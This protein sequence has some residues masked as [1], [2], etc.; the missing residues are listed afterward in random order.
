[1]DSLFTTRK[2][3]QKAWRVMSLTKRFN[4]SG[5][6]RQR[7]FFSRRWTRSHSTA[8]RKAP[9]AGSRDRDSSWQMDRSLCGLF[10]QLQGSSLKEHANNIPHPRHL[11]ENISAGQ[12]ALSLTSCI[13][14][15]HL[16]YTKIQVYL[17]HVIILNF[18]LNY[19]LYNVSFN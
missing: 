3:I 15:K 18:K 10:L 16:S 11:C 17:R 8:T 1:M 12:N 4:K 14:L 5:E 7:H 19:Y 13:V 2:V 6:T 9:S